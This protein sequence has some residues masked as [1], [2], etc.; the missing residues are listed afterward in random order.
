M[1]TLSPETTRLVTSALRLIASHGWQNLTIDAC[2]K[3]AKIK[4]ALAHNLCKRPVDLIPL[5]AACVDDQ[6]FAPFG[7]IS[8]SA[9]D[10]LFD[11]IMARFDIMQKHRQAFAAM[12]TA[13]RHDRALAVA[14]LRC[15]PDSGYRLIEAAHLPPP[16]PPRPVLAAGI[17]AVYAW[18]FRA[19]QSD[20]SR[21]MAKVMAATDR[22]LKWADKAA[23]LIPQSQ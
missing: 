22:A 13:A 20:T 5:I 8:G 9:H 11:L 19:W 18:A 23:K 14:L 10:R 6:A 17:I 15:T 7:K 21:D 3:A 12:A 2:A 4:P 1:S 16:Q